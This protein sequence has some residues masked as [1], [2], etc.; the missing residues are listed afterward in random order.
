M[1]GFDEFARRSSEFEVRA[2]MVACAALEHFCVGLRSLHSGR[3]WLLARL[4]DA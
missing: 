2:S 1:C 3:M 4:W